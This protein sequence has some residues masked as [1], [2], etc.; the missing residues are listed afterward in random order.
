MGQA[1]RTVRILQPGH[2]RKDRTAESPG[3]LDRV[4]GKGKQDSWE[5][6]TEIGNPRQDSHDRTVGKEQSGQDIWD[7]PAGTRQ[8]RQV[9]LEKSA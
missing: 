5:R 3:Q 8:P 4:T 6:A 7:T 2:Q 9:G 1:K